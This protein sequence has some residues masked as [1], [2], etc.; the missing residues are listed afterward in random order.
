MEL[1]D[2]RCSICRSKLHQCSACQK[3][4]SKKKSDR[5]KQAAAAKA[6]YAASPAVERLPLVAAPG[7]ISPE[8]IQGQASA[9]PPAVERLPIVAAPGQVSMEL[10]DSRCSI[11]RS[12]L[13]QCS[14][15]QKVDSKK[16]SDRRKQAA[17]A[18][19][20]YAAS[21]AVERLPLVAAPG[22][23]SPEAI[24]GQASAAPP[25]VERLPIV[26]AP[27]QVS[28]EA[29]QV[30]KSLSLRS[31]LRSSPHEWLM[32]KIPRNGHCLFSSF[33]LALNKLKIPS[34][35]KTVSELRAACAAQLY[36]WRGDIPGMQFSMFGDGKALVQ[37]FRGEKEKWMT[38]EEY[39]NLLRTSLY[40]GLEE[41]QMIVQMY[42][43]QVFMYQ[44]DAYHGGNPIPMPILMH[45]EL[46]VDDEMNA[47]SD[48]FFIFVYSWPLTHVSH[49]D[50]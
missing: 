8:A 30:P 11:C 7:P 34:C 3:V 31:V 38:L 6:A 12:K 1:L 47:G 33:V 13:H 18:K 25:A 2:S 46:S 49:P 19:A 40:G 35:P 37:T 10:L 17:A 44:A 22:P 4:D 39:C 29:I 36:E 48:V 27:E 32:C 20:A 50:K 24:Q 15:C 45:N 9:A 21:P 14:A 41:M 42:R 26:A 28:P 16:K 43:L 23:V 5:R